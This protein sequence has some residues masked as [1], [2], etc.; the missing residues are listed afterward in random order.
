MR[1]RRIRIG[2][3]RQYA[4]TVDPCDFAYLSRCSWTVLRTAW[5]QRGKPRRRL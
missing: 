2:P 5:P 3:Q 4:L 1:T